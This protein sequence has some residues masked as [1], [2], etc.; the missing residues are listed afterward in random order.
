MSETKESLKQWQHRGRGRR[1]F[2]GIVITFGVLFLS[3]YFVAYGWHTHRW[4]RAL[5]SYANL[6]PE[7]L[8]GLERILTE[9]G[10]TGEQRVKVKAILDG[11]APEVT[12]IQ[13]E[14]QALQSQF[15]QALLANH[16][17]SDELARIQT[18]SLHLTERAFSLSMD[19]LTKLS[20]VLTPL[21]RKRLVKA[22]QDWQG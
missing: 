18:A 17:S 21:Q 20:E 3:S 4:N 11:L 22:W 8:R 14:R 6:S 12:R 13:S 10:V 15:T 9:V 7:N 19:A 2:G 5:W 16:V 1:V